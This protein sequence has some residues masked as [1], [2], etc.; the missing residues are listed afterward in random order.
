MKLDTSAKEERFLLNLIAN[1]LM[2]VECV[3]L[4]RF[5]LKDQAQLISAQLENTARTMPLEWRHL[6]V[7][8]DTIAP[9]AKSKKTRPPISVHLAVTV[10]RAALHLLNAPLEHTLLRWEGQAHQIVR[11]VQRVT[12]ATE[13]V[14]TLTRLSLTALKAI[15]VLEEPR[16][17]ILQLISVTQVTCA[18]MEAVIN[19]YVCQEHTS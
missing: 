18:L 10:D 11:H 7:K 8:Q 17:W 5:A 2:E 9:W 6:T 16:S 3:F 4:V 12:F 15:T 1:L 14:L 19:K 13:K